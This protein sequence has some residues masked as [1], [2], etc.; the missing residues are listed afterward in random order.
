MGADMLLRSIY[1]PAGQNLNLDAA[2]ATAT[3]LAA[4]A[5]LRW[6]R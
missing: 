3:R 4:T 6:V 2:K 1:L 5:S